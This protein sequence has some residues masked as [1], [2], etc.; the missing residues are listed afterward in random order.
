MAEI[1]SKYD[2]HET[3]DL[4]QTAIESSGLKTISRINAQDNLK[5]AGLTVNGN[6]ILEVFHPKLAK[7]VF[8]ADIRAG[9]VPPVRIYVYEDSG[10]THVVT[11]NA[12]ELFSGYKNL[13]SMGRN[14]DDMLAK[15]IEAVKS[16][17]PP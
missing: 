2:F 13:S 6:V 9:I 3:V 12:T 4:L 8:D 17:T 7:E 10:K 5:K 16:T 1:T 14:V 11:Q 15:I